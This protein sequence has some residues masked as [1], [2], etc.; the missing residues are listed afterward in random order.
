M[1][2]HGVLFRIWAPKS[3]EVFLRIEGAQP[4]KMC[5]LELGFH[6]VQ[7]IGAGAGTRY[8]FEL[9]GGQ[10]IPDPLARFLPNDVH[11]PSEV[12][13]SNGYVWR[14]SEWKG[15][16]WEEAVLYE[17]HIGTFTPEGTFLAAISKLEQ[18]RDLGV[19]AIELLPVADFPGTRNWGY[20]GVQLF[21][22]DSS[23]GRPEHLKALV[24]AAHELGL[25]II[26]DVVYNHLGPE[27]NYLTACCPIFTER[28]HTPWGAAMNFDSQ[29]SEFVR[30]IVVSNA[31][32]WLTEFNFDGL[33]L[34]AVHAMKDDSPTHILDELAERA[35]SAVSDREVH[36][37]LEN[38]SN[39]ASWLRRDA[40]QTPLLYTA[41]WNDDFHHVLH[42]TSANELKG[43]YPEFVDDTEKLGR[44]LAEGFAFQGECTI[45]NP[46][47]RGEPS[48]FLPPTSFVSFLQNHDQIGNRPFGERFTGIAPRAAARAAITLHILSPHIPLLFM[49]EEWGAS[50]P[51]LFFSDVCEDLAEHVREGRRKEFGRYPDFADSEKRQ[52]I[53]DPLSL[54]TFQMSKL[55]WSEIEAAEHREWHKF[56][57][58]LL[59]VRRAEIV[60]RL[61]AIGGYAGTCEI[62][63]PQAVHV[64]WALDDGSELTVV[65]NLTD[66][67]LTIT[68]HDLG[69]VLW[70]EGSYT[71]DRLAP[72][73]VAFGL[74]ER[75][76]AAKK[77]ESQGA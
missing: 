11:G 44:V 67:W 65:T 4:R 8:M 62:L 33:R 43:L 5:A 61:K 68:I 34:D 48:A 74:R 51:F 56:Y 50:S 39:T 14:T 60:P 46:R 77:R 1:L 18:L 53:P 6:E 49:G 55:D 10:I 23:Y 57:R 76:E 7:V 35:R 32:Y 58:D 2:P 12:I 40:T 22:P 45:H 37:I 75:D 66:A 72:W 3:G 16:P 25:M 54:E 52:R 38:D 42:V 19:T 24:D 28:H 41:Q 36:L 21:A 13:D 64:A 73:T 59:Q 69:R 47:Q 17:V 31:V 26:L 71:E 15:R 63:G 20:D 9:E 27:G 30:E 70:T 29:G